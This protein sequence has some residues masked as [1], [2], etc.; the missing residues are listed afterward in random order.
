MKLIVRFYKLNN[1]FCWI[2][3]CLRP[4]HSKNGSTT[5]GALPMGSAYF[6]KTKSM[7]HLEDMIWM[8]LRKKSIIIKLLI[9]ILLLII[10]T[11][12]STVWTREKEQNIVLKMKD[13]L[14]NP[15][16]LEFYRQDI[17]DVKTITNSKIIDIKYYDADLNEDGFVDKIVYIRSP[18]HSGAH[19][20]NLS[21]L[22]NDGKSYRKIFS[23]S[24]PLMCQD[25]DMTVIGEMYILK[26]KTNGFYDIR[27][28]DGENIILLK[29]E[30]DIYS[31]TW[32]S[33]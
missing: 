3:F 20:D 29:Y 14:E 25:T 9:F 12:I 30:N 6:G 24:I 23:I 27:L 4:C 17:I 16:I 18:L 31:P 11:A 22:L 26:N 2:L 5:E 32:L 33:E 15:E 21:I 7:I 28:S 8:K 19:G 13:G 10:A 1:S